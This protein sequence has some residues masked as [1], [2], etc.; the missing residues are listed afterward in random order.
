MSYTLR[1]GKD[2]D[3]YSIVGYIDGVLG[4]GG[5]RGQLHRGYTSMC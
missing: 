1:N 4:R 3:V 2:D 5:I